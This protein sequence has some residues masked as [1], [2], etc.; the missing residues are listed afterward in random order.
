MTKKSLS[1][2]KDEINENLTIVLPPHEM[3]WAINAYH[4][5]HF[6]TLYVYGAEWNLF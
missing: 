1:Y 4:P 6:Q 5:Y 3:T 2:K